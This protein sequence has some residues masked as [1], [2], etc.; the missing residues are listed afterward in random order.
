MA[1]ARYT[2]SAD[3]TIV[4]AFEANLITRGSGSNMGYADSLEV[5]SIYGQESGS[6]GQTQELSR[7]LVDF[8]I[9]QISADRTAGTIPASGSVS[10]YLKLFNAKT[11]FTLPQGFTLMVT[12][13]SRSWVEGTGLDMDNYKD[14]GFANWM[15]SDSSTSWTTAGGDYR[16]VNN[17]KVVF[18]QGYENVELNVSN[19]VERWIAG[20]YTNYGF[21][22]HLTAS[23]EAYM[24]YTGSNGI[25][26]NLVG[27]AQSFYTKRFFSR[28][29]EFFFKRPLIEARWDSRVLDNRENCFYSSSLAPAAD[30]LNRL[31]LYN[32]IRGR[33]VNIPKVS[34]G[35]IRVSFYSGSATTPT[36]AK[37][38]LPIGGDVVANN[39][40]NATGSY[41]SRGLYYV[42][43]ALTAA[44]TPLQKI[45]DVWHS[46]T[47]LYYTGSFFPELM[48]TY[49]SAP[50]FTRVTSCKNLKKAYSRKDKTRFR[51]FVRNKDWN[52]TLYTVS[53]AVNPTEV[54]QSA[55]YNIRR[56]TDGWNAIPYGTGSQYSTYLSYDKEGNYF[57][58]DMSLLEGGYM[59]EMKL[60]YYNDSIGDWQEQPQAFKF[61]VKE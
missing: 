7:V 60:S 31:Y 40:V 8:P 32:Y 53:T 18:P 30:N 3:T 2:A 28:S 57:D 33:L 59:Y 61:R 36:G 34:T 35:N 37:I 46:G 26:Q 50:T 12:P 17:Y 51:F 56:V 58:F 9:A 43:V 44:A 21:G 29:T 10:F 47:V 5:F 23:E 1:I 15:K 11:P 48:P 25:L 45:Y 54:I 39:D 14:L 19:L 27:A 55:S 20:T 4:N 6:A 49:A 52:P 22:I 13:V 42:D 24:K 38:L 16:T 41:T